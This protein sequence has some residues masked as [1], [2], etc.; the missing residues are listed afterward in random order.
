ME[1]L[2]G[3]VRYKRDALKLT[4]KQLAEAAGATQAAISDIE[5]SQTKLPNP[6]IR[7]RLAK[8]LGVSHLALLVA[9]GEITEDEIEKVGAVGVVERDPN[10]PC[11]RIVSRVRSL[12]PNSLVLAQLPYVIDALEKGAEKARPK[13]ASPAQTRSGE[14]EMAEAERMERD[15]AESVKKRR[16]GE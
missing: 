16:E 12:P 11:E 8:A 2:A 7:R 5:R 4:Q 15:A 10:D 14:Q 1:G 13:G 9:A 3:Y 6:D